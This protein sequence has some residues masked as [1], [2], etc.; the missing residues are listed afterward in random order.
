MGEPK[1]DEE[2]GCVFLVRK[3]S[4]KASVKGPLPPDWEQEKIAKATSYVEHTLCQGRVDASTLRCHY[5]LVLETES[6]DTILTE[7]LA[8]GILSWI[9][10]PKDLEIRR[11]L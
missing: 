5:F 6:G 8:D 11:S 3:P 2:V 1:G 4:C 9:E 7:R 10:N